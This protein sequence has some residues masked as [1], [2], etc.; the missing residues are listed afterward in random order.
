MP[1]AFD[2]MVVA[3]RHKL[4]APL[5]FNVCGFDESNPYELFSDNM[6]DPKNIVESD[7]HIRFLFEGISVR[8]ELVQLQRTWQKMLERHAYPENVKT[9]LGEALA[10]TVLLSSTLKFDGNLTF[11]MQG[12]GALRLVVVQI[13]SEGHIRG[14]AR[15]DGEIPQGGLQQ[16]MGDARIVI[17]IANKDRKD[18]YQAIVPVQGATLSEC[19]QYY[20][21]ASVQVPTRLWLG[22]NNESVAGILLQRLPDETEY[23]EKHDEDWNRVC[24]LAE[25]VKPKELLGLEAPELLYRL[26]HEEHVGI[27]GSDNI[28]FACSCSSERIETTIKSL[29]QAE[30]HSIIEEM[31]SVEVRCEFCNKAY[32]YSRLD[33]DRLFESVL[34]EEN[35]TVH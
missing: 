24:I 35:R 21:N 28:V 27:V 10:A 9:I 31:G 17:T 15:W 3:V 23:K 1:G 7:H 4:I 22:V 12:D 14:L 18:P 5:L 26:F 11:Q 16:K 34:V 2:A 29:G 8:G 32:H 25:T 30:V 6:T 19:L 13:S 33:A 20:F